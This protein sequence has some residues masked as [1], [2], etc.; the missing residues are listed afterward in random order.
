MTILSSRSPEAVDIELEFIEPF[1]SISK[2]EFRSVE[3]DGATRVTWTMIVALA[4]RDMKNQEI[5]TTLGLSLRTVENH[6]G[7]AYAKLGV[8]SRTE[9][10]LLRPD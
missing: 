4:Q 5:A 8:R 9:L 7:R 6:L 10:A 1:A 2:T 3:V